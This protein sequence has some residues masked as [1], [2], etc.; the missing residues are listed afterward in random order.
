MHFIPELTRYLRQNNRIYTVRSYRYGTL[1]AA[2]PGIGPCGRK[3]V[4]QLSDEDLPSLESYVT[5]SGFATLGDWISKI[6][7]FIPP[8]KTM[9]LYKVEMVGK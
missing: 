5:E 3:L 9:Y 2:V 1:E 7:Q 6:R 4:A 8:G